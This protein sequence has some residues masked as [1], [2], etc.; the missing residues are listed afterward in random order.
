MITTVNIKSHNHR[1]YTCAALA[2]KVVS[3]I[4]NILNEN[5]GGDIDM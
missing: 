2:F 4:T 5:V 1:K 3:A